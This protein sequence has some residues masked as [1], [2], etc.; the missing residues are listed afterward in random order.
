MVTK[1]QLLAV[2]KKQT[3][4][5]TKKK[6]KKRTKGCFPSDIWLLVPSDGVKAS[7]WQYVYI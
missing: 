7:S 6:E 1:K 5:Q 4:K 2:F 3:N